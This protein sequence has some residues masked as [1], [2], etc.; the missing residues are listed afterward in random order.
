MQFNFIAKYYTFI[1]RAVFG[2]SLEK[3]KVSLFN[4]IPDN[5][6]VLIIGGGTGV[7]LAFLN[8]LKPQLIIHFVEASS[9]MVKIAKSKID[10]GQ[11]DFYYSTI[12]DFGGGNYD[13]IITEFFLDL[14]SENEIKSYIHLITHKLSKNGVWFDTDFRAT[15]SLSKK[16]LLK[17]MYLFFRIFSNVKVD[18]LI[19]T[20]KII[21]SKGLI[22]TKEK[23]FKSGFITSRLI[24]QQQFHLPSE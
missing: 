2:N 16:A 20:K 5:A 7:S 18:K 9:E 13:V 19:A 15:N 14:F 10:T 24:V 8:R 17:I 1:S 22:I 23:K 6:K 3:A 21:E 12:E 4:N 11:V